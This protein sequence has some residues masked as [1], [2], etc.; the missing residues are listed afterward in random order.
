MPYAFQKKNEQH[1]ILYMRKF[2]VFDAL[3]PLCQHISFESFEGEFIHDP[4]EPKA[5]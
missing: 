1:L 2:E 3:K 5:E 4:V